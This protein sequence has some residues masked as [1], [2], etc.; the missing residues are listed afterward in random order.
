MRKYDQLGLVRWIIISALAGIANAAINYYIVNPHTVVADETAVNT[1]GG[2]VCTLFALVYAFVLA[3]TGS[4]WKATRDA[5]RD[6]NK[7]VFLKEAPKRMPGSFWLAVVFVSLCVVV[8]YHLFHYDSTFILVATHMMVGMIIALLLQILQDLD[9][10]ITGVINVDEI[11][12][13]WLEKEKK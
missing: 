5:V 9:D 4:E 12:A 8:I 13:E 10:P 2:L 7:E 1:L 11:P 3:E 6:G